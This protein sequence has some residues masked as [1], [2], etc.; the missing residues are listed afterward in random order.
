MAAPANLREHLHDLRLD[1]DVERGRRLVGDEQVRLVGDGHGDHRPLSHAAGKF[2]RVLARAPLGIGNSNEVQQLDDSA[3]DVGVRQRARVQTDRFGDLRADAT[4]GIERRHRILEDHR[5][6]LAADRPHAL[7]AESRNVLAVQQDLPRH[8]L[9]RMLQEAHDGE[10]GDALA[11]TRLAD[12]AEH[13]IA[14]DVERDAV[15]E[16]RA[17]RVVGNFDDQVPHRQDRHA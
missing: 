14:M 5:H 12:D 9:D 11:R 4:H 1:R 13:F 15:D 2:I 16:A 6:A 17:A 10:H 3:A 7:E 8:A